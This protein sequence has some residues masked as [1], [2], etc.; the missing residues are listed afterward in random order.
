M[1]GRRLQIG[2]LVACVEILF[3]HRMAP[4]VALQDPYDKSADVFSY[5]MVLYELMTRKKPPPRKMRDGYAFDLALKVCIH[6]CF[7]WCATTTDSL[8]NKGNHSRW[9]ATCFVGPARGLRCSKCSK[10][11][12]FPWRCKEAP[13][14]QSGWTAEGRFRW[15]FWEGF[16]GGWYVDDYAMC[17][18]NWGSHF[19][20]F[21]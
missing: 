6:Y 14:Y 18:N 13:R 12:E 3:S 2:W 5:G 20:V 10:E 7:F 8:F 1:S 21:L 19:F 9:Y 15:S 11:T 16:W 4:E 17:N